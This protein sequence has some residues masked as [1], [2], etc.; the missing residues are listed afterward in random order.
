M[1]ASIHPR[2]RAMLARMRRF[3]FALL[4]PCLLAGLACDVF[5]PPPPPEPPPPGWHLSVPIGDVRSIND[6][7]VLEPRGDAEDFPAYHGWAVGT[8][9]TILRVDRSTD[10][11]VAWTREE[12]GVIADL[13]SIDVVRFGDGQELILAVGAA[14]TVLRSDG[15]GRWTALASGT[16][17]VL[18]DVTFR[19]ELDAFIV[20]DNGTILRFNGTVLT[21]QINQTLQEVVGGACPADGCGVNSTCGDDGNCH[22]FF[23]IPEPLKGVGDAG[24]MIAVGARGAVYRYDPN[25]DPSG[26]PGSRWVREDAGTQRSLASVDTESGVTVPTID[27]VLMRRNGDNDWNDDDFRVPSPVFLQDVWMRVSSHNPSSLNW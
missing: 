26:A 9:G 21:L 24:I 15:D 3:S 7:I 14:G 8:A 6:V 16:T 13:E 2:P 1:R 27:G 23:G 5:V 17:D 4:A 22:S 11:V 25:G 19:N 20:G 10:G 12:S 18:F